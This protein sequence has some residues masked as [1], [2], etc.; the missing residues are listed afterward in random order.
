MNIDDIPGTRASKNK[1]TD[2]TT[3]DILDVADI[4]GTKAR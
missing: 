2:F 3:R 1:Q 4:E